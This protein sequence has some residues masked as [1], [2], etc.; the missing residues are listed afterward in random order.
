MDPI[1]LA[2]TAINGLSLVLS[3]PALGG[4]SSIR[5]GEAS[6]LLG[7]LAT[8]LIEGDDARNDLIAFTEQIDAMV[9]QGRGPTPNEWAALRDRSDAAHDRL[10]EIED[11]LLEEEEPEAP[12]TEP[13]PPSE[14]E[15]ND[16]AGAPV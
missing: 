1:T 5:Q 6:E 10:Q 2:I 8:L 4:G 11:E 3:N 9:A 16:P 12:T 7:I 15:A 13:V 14:T